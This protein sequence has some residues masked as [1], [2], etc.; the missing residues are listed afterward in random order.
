VSELPD[1][2]R[3]EWTAIHDVPV[4]LVTGTNGK[5]TT[6]RLLAAMA[7]AAGFATGNTSTDGIY[8]DGELLDAGDWSGPGGGR[9]VLR[10]QRVEL[11]VLET[12]RG[13][14][15]RRGVALPRASV[16]IVT[17]VAEDHLGEFGVHDV[18]GLA[19]VKLVVGRAIPRT[20][21]V[22]LNADDPAV[23]RNAEQ[24]RAAGLLVAPFAWFGIDPDSPQ[25]RLGLEA[26]AE[27]ATLEDG[28]FV[29]RYGEGRELGVPVDDVPLTLRGAARHNVYNCLGAIAAAGGLSLPWSA[30]GTALRNFEGSAADN[31]GR[32][33]QYELGG[34]RVF[35]DFAHNPHGMEA[36]AGMLAALPGKRRLIVLGQGG[37]RDDDS[38]RQ[39]ARSAWMARPDHVIVKELEKY[40]RGR[41]PGEVPAIIESALIEAGA[42]AEALERADT[43]MDAVRQALRWAE[44]G[45]LILLIVHGQQTEATALLSSLAE[46]GWQPGAPIE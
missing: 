18:D 7:Q 29:Y 31:P 17:N 5:T 43:E 10:D 12:A 8:V 3:I 14:M 16:A 27:V 1:S 42:P 44:P 34:V 38:I 30:V 15:A 35:L 20:G 45:D 40:L 36:L 28:A 46:S 19:R 4:A 41:E 22:V 23:V 6:V 26:G 32:G 24:A 9:A 25:L 39:L 37:D 11:A 33:N 13:G 21:R 2:E